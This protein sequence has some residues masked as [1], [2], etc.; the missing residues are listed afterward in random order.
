MLMAICLAEIYK[1]I[2]EETKMKKT[3][4]INVYLSL[5]DQA[6]FKKVCKL[7]GTNMGGRTADLIRE[8][9]AKSKSK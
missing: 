6:E 3:M 5:K 8:D 7:K 4:S 1:T 9:V 2:K